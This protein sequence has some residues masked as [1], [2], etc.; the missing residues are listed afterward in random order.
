MR[1]VTAREDAVPHRGRRAEWGRPPFS[2]E[3]RETRAPARNQGFVAVGPSPD[4]DD[5]ARWLVSHQG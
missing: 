3:G 1:A 2:P 5:L 4:P